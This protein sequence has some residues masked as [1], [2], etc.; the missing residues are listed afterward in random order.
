MRTALKTAVPSGAC[1]VGELCTPTAAPSGV[2]AAATG[3]KSS[4]YYAVNLS[5]K[6]SGFD[7]NPFVDPVDVNPFQVS[8]DLLFVSK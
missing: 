5:S 8:S 1:V 4:F 2:T 6:M 7:S 3:R